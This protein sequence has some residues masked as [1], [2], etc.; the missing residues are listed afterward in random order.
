MK[1]G[2]VALGS[3]GDVQPY[4]ALGRGLQRAGYDVCIITHAVFEKF[5]QDAGL[6]FALV[7]I[8]PQQALTS[9]TGKAAAH[10]GNP[11]GAIQNFLRLIDEGLPEIFRDAFA[12]CQS[13]DA[14][15]SSPLGYYCAP[16]IAEKMGVP[17]INTYYL[18]IHPTRAYPNY[19]FATLQNRGAFLNRLTYLPSTLVGWIPI[20]K[21]INKSRRTVLGL[22]PVGPRYMTDIHDKNPMLYGFSPS[23]LPRADDWAENI[24]V[25]GY[26]FLDH[27]DSWQPPRDLVDFLDAGDKPIYVGFGSMN[28]E[29]TERTTE[30]ILEALRKTNQRA[31]ISTGWGGLSKTSASDQIFPIE[32]IPHDWLFPRMAAVIHHGGAGTTSA[33]LRAGVPSII[34]PFYLDQPFWG[35]RVAQ[36]GVGTVPIPQK[37]LSVENLVNAICTALDTLEIRESAAA[38]GTKIRAEDGIGQAVQRIEQILA[39]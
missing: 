14:I 39:K 32:S 34:V 15:F 24:T 11:L 28:T 37:E 10:S 5:V 26:W 13:C 8:D 23:V 6:Q 30:I 35:Y 31:V 29:N 20:L 21:T 19:L 7:R 17:L 9:N 12:A 4:V 25:T 3:R 22:P 36:L 18:P 27:P 2:I 1:I 38:L 16:H 33:G